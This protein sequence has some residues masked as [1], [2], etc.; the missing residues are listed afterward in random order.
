MP[1]PIKRQR[2][3]S[4]DCI[5]IQRILNFRFVFVSLLL[6]FM[7]SSSS[8]KKDEKEI[9][10]IMVNIK[11]M[12]SYDFQSLVFEGEEFGALKSGMESKYVK[13]EKVYYNLAYVKLYINGEEFILQPIDY[14]APELTVGDCTYALNVVNYDERKLSI[15]TLLK[16]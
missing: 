14:D 7:F 8:C 2:L 12:S 11:N 16:H 3:F 15:E 4:Q 1:P 10:G 6:I 13:F 9:T 5:S